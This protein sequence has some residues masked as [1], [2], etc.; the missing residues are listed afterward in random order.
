[1]NHVNLGGPAV[2]ASDTFNGYSMF[3]VVNCLKEFGF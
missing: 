1:M 2:Q 3:E